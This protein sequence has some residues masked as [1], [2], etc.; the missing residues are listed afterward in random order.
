MKGYVAGPRDGATA[1]VEE[2]RIDRYADFH[3][4][5]LGMTTRL[6]Q[7]ASP[8]PGPVLDVGASPLSESLPVL[9]PGREL[10]VVDPSP[11]WASELARTSVNF[12]PG[13]L[14]DARLPFPDG[15]FAVVVAA[16]VFEHLPECAPHLLERLA[17]VTAP[18]GIVA[19]TVP[20]QARLANRVRL[21]LGVSVVEPPSR[22]YHRPWMGFGHLHE[23]TLAEVL[24]EFHEPSLRRVALGAF[25]PYDRGK[26]QPVVSL[27][28]GLGLTEWREVLYA[29]F[30]REGTP[31]ARSPEGPNQPTSPPP[32]PAA[33]VAR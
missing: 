17:R 22:A 5:R 25:D 12:M 23:Y 11:Q 27:L 19:V 20:N 33:P 29:V 14:L 28:G 4:R 8:P 26:F 13:S 3:R 31:A 24:S 6:V 7:S 18:G 30:R 2:D 32:L 10:W 21:A 1:A 16:E 9:W 15:K